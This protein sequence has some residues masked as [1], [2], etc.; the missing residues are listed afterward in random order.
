M[1]TLINKQ[2]YILYGFIVNSKNNKK[3]KYVSTE[4][5]LSCNKHEGQQY[6]S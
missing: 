4:N 3:K 5:D 6:E 2:I 1:A